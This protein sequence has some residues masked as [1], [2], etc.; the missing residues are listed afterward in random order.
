MF[1]KHAKGLANTTKTEKGAL[2]HKHSESAL[3]DLFSQGGAYRGRSEDDIKHLVSEAAAENL[4]LTLRCLFYLRDARKGQGERR[5]FRV[6]IK[7]LAEKYPDTIEKLFEYFPALGRWDD[8]WF[9][10]ENT[11]LEPKMMYHLKVTLL[12]DMDCPSGSSS[13]LPKWLP[14]ENATSKNTK[15]L[16]K[17]FIKYLQWSPKKY[18]QTLSK[19]RAK[20]DVVERKMCARNWEGITY[21][22]VPSKAMLNYRKSYYKRDETRFKQF[23]ESVKKGEKKINAS[24][25]YPYE[26]VHQLAT[27][28]ASQDDSL[29][30]LWNALPNYMSEQDCLVVCDTSGSMNSQIGGAKARCIDVA[31]SL[32]IYTAERNHGPYK[33][34]FLSFSEQSE[35]VE[36]RGSS[37][38]NK[39]RNAASTSWGYT[40][41]LQ[42]A[43]D[44]ILK[45]AIKHELPA[46]EMPKTLLVISDM[47]FDSATKSGTYGHSRP[48]YEEFNYEVAREKFHVNG[49]EM[50][51][52]VFW[53]V[54]QRNDQSVLTKDETGMFMV[55]G[56]SPS[57][58]RSVFNKS[59][60]TPY[61]MM[62]EVINAE[63]YQGI[64]V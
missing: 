22:H 31:V 6:G 4:Q 52:L 28:Y 62:L 20:L 8:L 7:L 15:R 23:I 46:S 5:L 26:I 18:R 49:Y 61:E 30:A 16:A 54:Q 27:S 48:S 50:P 29:D 19:L 39:I 44:L 17:K 13:L 37:L 60:R 2:T 56:L 57:I 47:E 42:S 12:Q 55:S 51:D 41:N 34:L 53:T 43:F 24:T 1:A 63:R 11:S 35:F 40:T 21:S 25:L 38:R 59:V 64:T 3:L 33:N 58:L 9:A 45:T 32:A 14:S 36:V 10:L